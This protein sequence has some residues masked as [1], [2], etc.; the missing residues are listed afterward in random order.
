MPSALLPLAWMLGVWR[1]DVNGTRNRVVDYPLDFRSSGYEETL[2]ISLEVPLMFG[3]PSIIFTSTAISKTDPD[4]QH[5]VQG[6]VTI[7]NR[8]DEAQL[9]ALSSVSNLGV[10]MI[11]EG[12]LHGSSVTLKPR[13]RV[14][15]PLIHDVMPKDMSRSFLKNGEKLLQSVSKK[16]ADGKNEHISKHYKKI[17]HIEY[18]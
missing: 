9:V 1:T 16:N 8:P 11:E 12:E 4:D 14:T 3:T 10:M 17:V 18:L 2:M 5:V 6:F 13:Y 15:H 7:R